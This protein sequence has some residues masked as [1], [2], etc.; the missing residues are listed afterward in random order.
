MSEASDPHVSTRSPS[1]TSGSRY[2]LLL[3]VFCFRFCFCFFFKNNII[4]IVSL[5]KKNGTS[6]PLAPAPPPPPPRPVPP[7]CPER[8]HPVLTFVQAS[9]LGS[10][11]LYPVRRASNQGETLQTSFLIPPGGGGQPPA[12]LL[13]VNLVCCCPR[14][15][16]PRF[17]YLVLVHFR[18][19]DSVYDTVLS[20]CYH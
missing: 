3:S 13:H 8:S 9:S 4:K 19:V 16:P 11:V 1:V 5:K 2:L 17:V 20:M 18:A 15:S 6:P 14:S 10:L 7:P 12:S